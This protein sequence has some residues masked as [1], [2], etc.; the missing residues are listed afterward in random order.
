MC[1][2]YLTSTFR[3][4]NRERPGF[5]SSAPKR[6]SLASNLNFNRESCG[7][8]AAAAYETDAD[9]RGGGGG[10]EEKVENVVAFIRNCG[11]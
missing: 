5:P 4:Y 2:K 7:T 3:V 10:G 1:I 9:K 11:N 6:R 8:I